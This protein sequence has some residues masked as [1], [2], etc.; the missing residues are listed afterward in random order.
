MQKK[1]NSFSPSDCVI[2]EKKQTTKKKKKKFFF[3]CVCCC[4]RCWFVFLMAQNA[5][6]GSVS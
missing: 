5:Q 2:V 3:V 6:N 4:C 1:V